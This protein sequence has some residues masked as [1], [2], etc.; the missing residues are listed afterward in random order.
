ME[1]KRDIS[2]NTQSSIR[3]ESKKIIYFDPYKIEDKVNDADYIFI[4]H[5]HYDHFDIDSINNI[6]KET[7]K[8][9]VPLSMKSDVNNIVD[10]SNI[11]Y[12]LP[13]TEC[14]IDDISF[15]TTYSYN[16]NKEFHKKENNFV[17]YILDFDGDSYYVAGDT[18]FLEEN[19]EINVDVAIIPIG[20]KFTMDY[21]EA[22][23]FINTIKPK[24]VIPTHYGSIIGDKELGKDFANLIDY[25]IECDLILM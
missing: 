7:T 8:L 17:G 12:V 11:L 23:D 18:D 16:I 3:I 14:K 25:S 15:K 19:K 24:K 4:T 21:K 5:N 10:S 2:I 1:L 6:K 9:I 20:G 13:N 22:A